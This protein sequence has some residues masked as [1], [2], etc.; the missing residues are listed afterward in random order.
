MK[1]ADVRKMMDDDDRGCVWLSLFKADPVFDQLRVEARV[2]LSYSVAYFMNHSN[3]YK[4]GFN[5]VLCSGSVGTRQIRF[6]ITMY[7]EYAF[8]VD[9]I[10][11]DSQLHLG[12][13]KGLAVKDY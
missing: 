3:V 12:T 10:D 8:K 2:T 1:I 7:S 4:I 9:C 6:Y 11:E 5:S 13:L